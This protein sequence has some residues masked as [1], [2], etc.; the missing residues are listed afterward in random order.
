VVVV[1]GVASSVFAARLTD[2]DPEVVEGLQ[3][4]GVTS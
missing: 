3:D 1:V 4:V 2:P